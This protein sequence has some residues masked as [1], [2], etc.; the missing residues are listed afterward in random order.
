MCQ[1][2][3]VRGLS[4][5]SKL[6]IFEAN[7]GLAS[8]ARGRW[9][10]CELKWNYSICAWILRRICGRPVI[11]RRDFTLLGSGVRK[12]SVQP[13]AFLSYIR[14]KPQDG[15]L[16]KMGSF[17]QSKRSDNQRYA[18]EVR[19]GIFTY[20]QPQAQMGSLKIINCLDWTKFT[21]INYLSLTAFEV[22]TV[23]DRVFFP[24]GFMAQARATEVQ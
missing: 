12:W 5:T 7:C 21:N 11:L 4:E 9:V 3:W 14:W 16:A 6:E 8:V 23:R 18:V 17:H 22:H 15:Q 1:G 2:L 19:W 20:F 24:L 10:C 13:W